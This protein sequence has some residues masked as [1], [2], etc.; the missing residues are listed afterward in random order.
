MYNKGIMLLTK[1]VGEFFGLDIGTT[2]VRVVQLAR[3]G[4]Q[5]W[6][7]MHYAHVPIDQKTAEA[8]TDEARRRLS[9]AVTTAIGQSGVK[10]KNVAIGLPSS[11]TFVTVVDMPNVSD[12]ELQGMIAYQT[13]EFIPMASDDMKVDWK[14][15]GPAMNDASKQEVLLASTANGFVE[16]RL[17]LL[18]SLGLNVIAAEPDSIAM[19]RATEVTDQQTV[20]LVVDFGDVS[21]DVVV[22]Y[23]GMPRLVRTIPNGIA[24]LELAV[25]QTLS[26]EREQAH[27]F[28]VKFGLSADKLEGQ[29]VRALEPTI[30]GFVSELRKSI[31]FFEN[32][33]PG[34]KVGEVVVSGVGSSIP[35]LS[36]YLQTKI[37]L[38]V[39]DVDVWR[40][41]A[42]GSYGDA[43]HAVKAE[44]PVAIGLAERGDKI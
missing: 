22:L 41:I 25:V 6:T 1:G 3:A 4:A 14:K 38:P 28:I 37:A 30:V 21:T 27:Q 24:A 42:T 19:L 13:E 44:F 20:R 17:E 9:E 11:K 35:G 29:V 36:H 23:Q 5:K 43:L 12:T 34:V 15:L 26:V 40:S 33:Y 7:L 31:G 32:R 10:T 16:A 18:E 8:E 2:A 39:T